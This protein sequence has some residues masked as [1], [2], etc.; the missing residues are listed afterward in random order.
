MEMVMGVRKFQKNK[1]YLHR[2]TFD[3][4]RDSDQRFRCQLATKI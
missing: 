3:M 2:L 1:Y 4:K